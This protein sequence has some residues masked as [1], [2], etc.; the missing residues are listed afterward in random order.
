MF[1]KTDPQRS[2]LECEFL[3]PPEKAERLKR[4]WAEPFRQRVLPL[5]DEEV[6]RDAFSETTGRPNKSIRLMLCLHI[7]KEWNNLTDEQVLEQLEFNLLWQHALGITPEE[8]HTCQ[9]SMHSFRVLLMESRRAQKEFE[10]ITLALS[11]ADGVKLGR[12]RLDST[13]V[14]SNIAVLTRLGLFVETVTSFLRDLRREDPEAFD[15]LDEGYARRYLDREG[16]FSDAK[17]EQARRR[18]PLVA[19]DVYALVSYFETDVTVRAMPSFELLMRLFEE[20]CEVVTDDDDGGDDGGAGNGTDGGRLRVKTVE[21]KTVNS[22]SL[23]SPHDPDATYGHKGKGYE[24]Q[25]SETCSDDN[26]YQLVTATSVNGAHESDQHAVVPMLDQ[27]DKSRMKPEEM[28]ADTGYGS[29][30]NIVE[31][32]RRGVVLLA[33]VQD[34]AAPPPTDHFAAPVGDE[35]LSQARAES[36]DACASSANVGADTSEVEPDRPLGLEAFSFNATFEQVVSCPAGHAPQ[37]QQLA[38]G[39]VIAVFSSEHCLGCPMAGRCPTRPL[40]GGDRQL[41]RVPATIATETRQ[42]EQQQP[43]FKER[44]KKRSGIESTNHELKSR[45]GLGDLRIRGKPRV[46][47]AVTLKALALN[48]KRVV[49]YHVLQM[50]EC[51]ACPC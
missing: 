9:K 18:L 47:L 32:A 28:D 31:A 30:E 22:D 34:P 6:F 33:P 1:R 14:L 45:H 17:R 36:A 51:A 49:Q 44:Y 13:H 27:L 38:G 8:A 50:Y 48:V 23:Q 46:V 42:H 11:E 10:K 26:P 3:V 25:A 7:L 24:V 39:Q 16:Y 19:E 4:S 12:Q 43:A 37:H 41:R 29:G 21:P 20:Q 40:S 15:S 2:L 35:V 5:V